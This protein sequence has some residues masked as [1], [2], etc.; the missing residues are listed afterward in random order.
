MYLQFNVDDQGHIISIGSLVDEYQ[1]NETLPY[2]IEVSQEQAEVI[3]S[4]IDSYKL[5]DGELT[6]G[7]VSYPLYAEQIRKKIEAHLVDEEGYYLDTIRVYE[8]ELNEYSILEQPSNNFNQRARWDFEAK[9]WTYEPRPKS[10]EE[11]LEE[12]NAKLKQENQMT[13]IA[14]ME[15]TESILGGK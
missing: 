11:L 10:R 6:N 1:Y 9:Q 7:T 14:M 3:F 2:C 4:N 5:V 12:E 8:E 13:A 15:L